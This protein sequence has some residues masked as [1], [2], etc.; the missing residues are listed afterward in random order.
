MKGGRDVVILHFVLPLVSRPIQ[1]ISETND[2]INNVT[3]KPFAPLPIKFRLAAQ[4]NILPLFPARTHPLRNTY[5]AGHFLCVPLNLIVILSPYYWSRRR[6]NHRYSLRNR[7]TLSHPVQIWSGMRHTQ[8]F[9]SK[10]LR[11][12]K[13]PAGSIHIQILLSS[14]KGN[15]C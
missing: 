8:I 4:N 12:F 1:Q 13:R 6:L 7:K 15:E 3:F 5:F 14:V 10:W 9:S 11:I 2:G